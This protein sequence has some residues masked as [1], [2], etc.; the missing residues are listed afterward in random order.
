MEN[1]TGADVPAAL[2]SLVDGWCERRDLQP[3][4]VLLPAYTSNNGLTDGWGRV[5]DALYN[6][7]ALRHHLPENERT[8]ID[9]L[10]P[11]V[12]AAVYRN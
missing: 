4:T 8:T 6:L 11:L 9:Q 1:L 2:A 7:R 12:E 10:I 5:M 3:L